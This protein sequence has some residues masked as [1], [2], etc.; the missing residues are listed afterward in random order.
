MMLNS[1][2]KV[3]FKRYIFGH[4]PYA[5]GNSRDKSSGNLMYKLSSNKNPY[6]PSTYSMEAIIRCLLQGGVHEYEYSDERTLRGA[7]VICRTLTSGS[8]CDRQRGNSG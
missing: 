2:P 8:V 7:Y 1:H 3:Q 6:G 5:G 4:I